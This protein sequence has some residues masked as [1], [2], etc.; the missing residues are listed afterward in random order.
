MEVDSV[1]FLLGFIAAWTRTWDDG[2]LGHILRLNISLFA[3][4]PLEI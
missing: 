2:N 3:G 1:A 4:L